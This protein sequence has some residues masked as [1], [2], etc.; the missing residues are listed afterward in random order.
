MGCLEDVIA[1]PL[2]ITLPLETI[3]TPTT[4]PLEFVITSIVFTKSPGSRLNYFASSY[5]IS[6]KTFRRPFFLTVPD[7]YIA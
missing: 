5:D 4:L 2:S 6:A 3:E 1:P 7:M